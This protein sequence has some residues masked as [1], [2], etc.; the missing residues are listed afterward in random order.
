MLVRL[1]FSTISLHHLIAKQ[2]LDSVAFRRA[3]GQVPMVTKRSVHKGD[4]FRQ[5]GWRERSHA[6][7]GVFGF[8]RTSFGVLTA[9]R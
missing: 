4:T 7:E 1:P 6:L 9:K 3:N 8:G 5:A 2:H